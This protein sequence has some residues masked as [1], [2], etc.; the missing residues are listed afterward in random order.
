[1]RACTSARAIVVL[2]STSV[3]E[4]TTRLDAFSLASVANSSVRGM[5]SN[6]YILPVA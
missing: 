1:M 5:L 6:R 3:V 2:T 4:T